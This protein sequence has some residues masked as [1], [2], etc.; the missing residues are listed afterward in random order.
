M[1]DN[2]MMPTVHPFR[3]VSVN[4]IMSW[5]I[6]LPDSSIKKL[7]ILIVMCR[8][9]GFTWYKMLLDWS[10]KSLT[11]ALLIVQYRFGQIQSIV[12]DKGTN[13]IPANINPSI[14]MDKEERRLMSL[15][16]TQTPVGGQHAKIVETR[17]KLIKKYCFN[18]MNKVKGEKI[19]PI[20]MFQ[21]AGFGCK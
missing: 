10:S 7:S 11:L 2:R 5:P 17:I 20:F 12:S 9:T 19:Q 3:M 4:P 13:L 21:S 18:L 6:I 14:T 8:Q 1:S 16:H 15:V